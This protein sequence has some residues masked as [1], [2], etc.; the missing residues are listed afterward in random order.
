VSF[1]AFYN[2]V[3]AFLY[4]QVIMKLTIIGGITKLKKLNK[5]VKQF[6]LS[7]ETIALLESLVEELNTTQTEVLENAISLMAAEYFDIEERKEI[8]SNK[9]VELYFQEKEA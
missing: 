4:V 8:I 9:L 2:L 6:R 1:N 7:V 3:V 5:I